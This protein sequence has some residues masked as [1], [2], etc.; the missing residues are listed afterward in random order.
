M[1]IHKIIE[2]TEMKELMLDI[3]SSID[4]YCRKNGLRYSLAYGTLIG[5]IRHKGYIP[6][7]D[8]IDIFMPR[9]DYMKFMK[10]FN[11]PYY[12]ACCAEYTPGWDH[13]IAKVCDDRTVID[14]GHGD[15]SGVYV[16]VFPVDGWPE[17]EDEI[18]KHYS[19]VVRYLRLWSSL[20]YTQHMKIS[21]ANG[22]S[23]NVKIVAS[24]FLGLF[25]NSTRAL[26]KMLKAKT[27]YSYET[28]SKVGS[29][30]CGDWSVPR[31]YFDNLIDCPF[32]DRTYLVSE[33]YD[34]LLRVYFGDYMQL[35]PVEQRVS[36]HG[37]TAYWK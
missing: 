29:L 26:K 34:A 17:G 9:P 31:Y 19:K 28:S 36:N 23:K 20:H 5:A 10:E 35:P 12:K 27:Q 1:G 16:D 24:K 11:H 2:V 33:Q 13:F 14:E 25:T 21:R 18:K 7:D 3:M 22:L 6:W 30:T 37:Y 32:E 8:D 4:E 15:I